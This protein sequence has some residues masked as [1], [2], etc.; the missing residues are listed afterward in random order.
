M[1]SDALLR[2]MLAQNPLSRN[3]REIPSLDIYP[4][5]AREFSAKDDVR[6]EATTM[7]ACGEAQGQRR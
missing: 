5:M 7:H 1:A 6:E 2:S 4:R 3:L